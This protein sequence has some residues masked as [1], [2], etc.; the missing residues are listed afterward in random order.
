[1]R[2]Q[3]VLQESTHVLENTE[4]QFSTPKKQAMEDEGTHQLESVVGKT[5]QQNEKRRENR[6]HS[7]PVER[8]GT[9]EEHRK[10]VCA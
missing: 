10:N 9:N 4:G 3:R 7:R 6:G 8:R 1:M 5:S 2:T